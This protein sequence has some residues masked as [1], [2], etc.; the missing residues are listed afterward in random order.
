[1][2]ERKDE[3][4]EDSYDVK[5][6]VKQKDEQIEEQA[7]VDDHQENPDQLQNLILEEEKVD[8]SDEGEINRLMASAHDD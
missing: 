2:H 6:I 3:E 5:V 8:E 4:E 7:V 1:M